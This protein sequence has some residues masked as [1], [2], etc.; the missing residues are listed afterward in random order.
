MIFGLLVKVGILAI[1]EI[2]ID[3]FQKN[4][5]CRFVHMLY[6]LGKNEVLSIVDVMLGGCF[7]FDGKWKKIHAK[8]KAT[9]P[10][11]TKPKK[12]DWK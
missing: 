8:M 12:I 1:T 6:K 2:G 9:I 7:G 11:S 5:T 4:G 3:I 10:A